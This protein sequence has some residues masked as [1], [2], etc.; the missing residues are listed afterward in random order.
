MI[1]KIIAT[2]LLIIM[3]FVMA[4]VAVGEENR[5]RWHDDVDPLWDV[6]T[7]DWVLYL[8]FWWLAIPGFLIGNW[9][10]EFQSREREFHPLGQI[11]RVIASS[12]T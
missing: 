11:A 5:N 3:W 12:K 6:S 8:F 7:S 1:L 10:G 4:A 9:Y 2:V